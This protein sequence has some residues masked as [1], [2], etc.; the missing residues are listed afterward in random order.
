MNLSFLILFPNSIFNVIITLYYCHSGG[1]LSHSDLFCVPMC[2]INGSVTHINGV[3]WR[4][5]WDY[6][7]LLLKFSFCIYSFNCKHVKPFLCVNFFILFYFWFITSFYSLNSFIQLPP[8]TVFP[9][10]ACEWDCL[11]YHFSH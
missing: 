5:Q 10:D 9:L 11:Y 4:L 7:S 1:C 2:I 3:G 8:R 6:I